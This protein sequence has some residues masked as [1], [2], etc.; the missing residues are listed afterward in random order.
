VSRTSAVAYRVTFAFLRTVFQGYFRTQVVG[1][2]NLPPRGI[3]TIVVVNHASAL[4]VPVMGYAVGREGH[5]L[6]KEEATRAP[7]MGWYLRS[8]GAIPTRRDGQDTPAL[9][10]TLE[11]LQSGDLVG[12]APEGTRSLD[13]SLGAYDPGFVWL[14]A[15]TGAFVVPCAVYGARELMPKGALLPHPGTIR[16]RIGEPMHVADR[17]QRLSRAAMEEVARSVRSRTLEMLACMAHE[18]GSRRRTARP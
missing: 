10:A 3:P 2:E 9:R 11:A 14:A 16:V 5:F 1:R 17:G 13:G 12:L 18:A 7:L 6:A 15:R 8:V 4:D